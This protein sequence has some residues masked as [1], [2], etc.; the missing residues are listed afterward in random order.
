MRW[1]VDEPLNAAAALLDG[2]QG[3][4]LTVGARTWTFEELRRDAARFAGVL[5]N[6]GVHRRDRVWIWADP[7]ILHV[8]AP[9]GTIWFG[10]AYGVLPGDADVGGVL[11]VT[12]AR[13]LL[14]DSSRKPRVDPLRRDLP[15]LWHVVLADDGPAKMSGGDFRLDDYFRGAEPMEPAATLGYEPAI[16]LPDGTMHGQ[17]FLDP[18]VSLEPVEESA[19]PLDHPLLLPCVLAPAWWRGRCMTLG[20][21]SGLERYWVPPPLITPAAVDGRAVAP[22]ETRDGVVGIRRA[23]PWLPPRTPEEA[24][25]WVPLGPMPSR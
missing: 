23:F 5:K 9:L 3:P 17:A 22:L 10:A 21:G 8:V 15:E 19:L 14:T 7:S 25:E 11:R 13:M 18:A 4:A 6:L 24:G 1:R 16:V 2:P 20:R 12:G